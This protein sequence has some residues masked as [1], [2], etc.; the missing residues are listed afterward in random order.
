MP[1]HVLCQLQPVATQGTKE[2]TAMITANDI[3][4]GVTS[5]GT[6]WVELRWQGERLLEAGE[7]PDRAQA[8]LRTVI[9]HRIYRDA[10]R[11]VS[12]MEYAVMSSLRMEVNSDQ[13]AA[14]FRRL[15]ETIKVT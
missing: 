14:M 10:N 1:M 2:S 11:A 8:E 13:I 7:D 4:T 12:E 6:V 15:R 5:H 3:K 9:L